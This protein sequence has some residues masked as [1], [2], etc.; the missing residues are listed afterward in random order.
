MPR[1]A[2]ADESERACRFLFSC[3]IMSLADADEFG[4][5]ARRLHR[6]T[7]K[8]F[9]AAKAS[10]AERAALI[11]VAAPFEIEAMTVDVESRGLS[12]VERRQRAIAHISLWAL[13]LGAS[14]LVFDRH[15]AEV[16][17]RRTLHRVV[18]SRA[19]YT[20]LE[21][22]YVPGLWLPDLIAWSIGRSDDDR[23]SLPQRWRRVNHA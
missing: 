5:A 11:K 8:R 23:T 2:F 20:H 12:P 17:D 3:V 18:G 22:R 15:T 10:A 1:R 7:Q 6:P 14:E 13:G 9:H 21:A 16:H 19:L 4:V